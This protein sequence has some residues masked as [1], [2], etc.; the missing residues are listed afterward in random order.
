MVLELIQNKS[1]NGY[2]DKKKINSNNKFIFVINNPKG[3]HS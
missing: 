3:T 2:H 1:K